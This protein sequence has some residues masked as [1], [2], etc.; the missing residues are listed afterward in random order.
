MNL[1]L[2]A[3]HRVSDA[4]RYMM[5]LSSCYRDEKELNPYSLSVYG[6]KQR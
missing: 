4:E 5:Q 6:V 1:D 2:L 3:K